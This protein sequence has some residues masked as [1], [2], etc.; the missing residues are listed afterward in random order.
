MIEKVISLIKKPFV[1]NVAVLTTGMISA[2]AITMLV[3]PIITRLYGPGAYGIM[4]SFQAIMQIIIPVSALSM[5]I[6]IVLP[7]ENKEVKGIIKLSFYIT[8]FFTVLSLIIILI[9]RSDIVDIF[10]IQELS[11][12]LILIPFVILFAGIAQIYNQW[13]IREKKFNISAKTKFGDK[14]IINSGKLFFGFISPSADIL[15][16]FAALTNGIHSL[17]IYILTQKNIIKEALKEKVSLKKIFSKYKDFPLFRAPEVFINAISGNLP[18]LLLTAFF[19]PASAGF[20][21]IG[22]SVLG[23]P[24]QLIGKSI[25]DVFYPRISEGVNNKENS[26]NMIIKA[27]LILGAIGIIPFGLIILF[28]PV[29]FDFVFGSSWIRAGEYARWMAIWSYVAFMNRPSVM[30]LPVLNAQKFHLIYTILI[31]VI[32]IIA[33]FIGFTV[34]ENDLIA[35]ALFGIVGAILNVGLILI[36]LIISKRFDDKN[37]D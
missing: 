26:T 19:G 37:I 10:Q 5:P 33:L 28:G 36:T 14:V 24:S 11:S 7:K 27:T 12:Y 17:L 15:V 2:Q 16:F 34:F 9:F 3:S 29:L 4:G 30:A 32:R 31:L 22:R 18:V 23:I 13:L 25:G 1:K 6:A 8:S 35:I 20:F 21:T